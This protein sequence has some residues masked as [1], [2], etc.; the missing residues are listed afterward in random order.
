MPN[1][2]ATAFIEAIRRAKNALRRLSRTVRRR[3]SGRRSSQERSPF[4]VD[5]RPIHA[6]VALQPTPAELQ[7]LLSR[8]AGQP[9]HSRDHIPVIFTDST[10]FS[11]IAES[12]AVFEYL[13]DRETWLRHRPDW[14]WNGFVEQRLAELD[15]CYRPA[16]TIVVSSPDD[17]RRG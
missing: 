6:Y 9:E 17:P 1:L 15:H 13:P 11:V 14:P 12:G 16:V 7:H 8:I 4:V 5:T 2:N 3:A 10:D